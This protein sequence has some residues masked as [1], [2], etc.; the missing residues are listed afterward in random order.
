MQIKLDDASN[1]DDSGSEDQK[2]LK[3]SLIGSP[4]SL[5]PGHATREPRSCVL[6]QRQKRKPLS[7]LL[8]QL[9]RNLEKKDQNQFFAWPVTDNYAPNYSTI[10]KKPMDFSTMKQKIDD[11]QYKSLNCFIVR[12]CLY[13]FD[14][15]YVFFI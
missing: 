5:S 2:R 15:F 6:N 7:R 9:L 13:I 11:N 3:D 8:E 1:D 14:Y 10:I 4:G 12:F